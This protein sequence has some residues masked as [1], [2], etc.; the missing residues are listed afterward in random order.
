M[1]FPLQQGL[2]VADA[3]YFTARTYLLARQD[4]H[5]AGAAAGLKDTTMP[6]R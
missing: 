1:L 3:C 5:A 4:A 2:F 6:V